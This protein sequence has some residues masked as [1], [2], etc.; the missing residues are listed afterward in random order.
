MYTENEIEGYGEGEA[1]LVFHHKNGEF[2]KYEPKMYS[3]MA[4]GKNQVKHGLFRDLVSTRGNRLMFFVLVMCFALVLI[5]SL[6]SG[7]SEENA[8]D[9]LSFSLTAFEFS[10][11][12]YVSVDIK[13]LEKNEG[14]QEI[15]KISAT[16][17]AL[18]SDGQALDSFKSECLFDE[19]SDAKE[20]LTGIFN[21]YDIS[22]VS[23]LI[24][25]G[26]KSCTISGK[27]KHK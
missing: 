4:T 21:D 23:C 19:K 22:S 24:T 12:I 11:K 16:V 9:G 2:R 1:P 3:D 17:T 14:N 25:C 7:K 8:I 26:D 13:K 18:S 10:E 15:K 27:V 5:V 20:T 6:L